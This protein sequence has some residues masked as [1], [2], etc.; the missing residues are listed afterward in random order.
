M[1]A[2]YNKKKTDTDT[3]TGTD[4]MGD[5]E[6]AIFECPECTICRLEIFSLT[7]YTGNVKYCLN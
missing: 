4:I 6:H 2:L 1:Y 7:G 5:E 3:D